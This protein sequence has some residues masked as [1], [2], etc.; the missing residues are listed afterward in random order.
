M[1]KGNKAARGDYRAGA[2]DL[3]GQQCGND[4]STLL[5]GAVASPPSPGSM[6]A[7]SRRIARRFT[8]S[9]MSLP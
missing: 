6:R 5:Q 9:M 3:G 4:L 7:A 1:T 2:R 8:A